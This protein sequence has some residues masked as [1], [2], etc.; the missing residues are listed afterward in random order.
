[1]AAP[2]SAASA[3]QGLADEV[4]SAIHAFSDEDAL[5]L[6][7]VSIVLDDT[8]P[9][10]AVEAQVQLQK[11]IGHRLVP[12]RARFRVTAA[13]VLY[14]SAG[15]DGTGFK[16][17]ENEVPLLLRQ[18]AVGILWSCWQEVPDF[19]LPTLEQ[20]HNS[21]IVHPSHEGIAVRPASS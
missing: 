21:S 18:D 14:F 7:P 11:I 19:R 1:M 16:S 15:N 6:L 10:H 5:E 12:D 17:P 9:I 2:G 20:P 4:A 13:N 8:E 3:R